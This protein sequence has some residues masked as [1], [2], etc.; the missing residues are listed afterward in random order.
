MKENVAD[1]G[2]FITTVYAKC[3]TSERR[4][5]W[6]NIHN[7]NNTIDG[8]WCIG[9]DFNIIMDTIEKLGGNP[10]RAYRS[11]V[12]I[13]TMESYGLMDIG[14]TGPRYTWCNNRRP[15]KRIWKRLDRIK[16]NDQWAQHF[17]NNTVKHFVRNGSDHRVILFKDDDCN[18]SYFHSILRDSRRRLQLHRMKNHRDRWIQGEDRIVKAAVKHFK[19][20]FNLNQQPSVSNDILNCIPNLITEQNNKR[21]IILPSEE[22]IKDTVFSMSIES[23]AGPDGFNEK[24]FQATWDIIKR[25][26]IEIVMDFFKGKNLTKFYSHTCIALIPKARL[27][28]LFS[29]TQAR[30]SF[31]PSLFILVAEV[32]TRSL[33]NLIHKENFTSFSMNK[34]GPQINYLAYADDIVIFCGGNSKTVKTVIK[35]IRKYEKASGQLVNK[36][37]SF[38]LTG[39]KTSAYR[40]NRLR[41]CTGFMD[42]SFPFTY[43]GCP[44]YVGRKKICFFDNMVTKIIKS[45]NGWQGKMLTYGRRVVLIKSVLQP[46]PTYTLTALNPPKG[47]LNLIEKH[48]DRFLWGTTGKKNNYHCSSWKILCFPKEEGDIEIKSLEDISATLTIKRWWRFRTIPLLWADFLRAKYCPRTHPVKK[49]WI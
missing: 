39:P 15:S 38:F 33:N 41:D 25:D 20:F 14:F 9:G 6:D 37:K 35:E 10:H 5:L 4:D 48:M 22:E 13:S 30:G 43:L 34:R 17:Q 27:L 26:I 19:S 31:I 18:T 12:F 24:K 23:S 42:K 3:T 46:L 7:M 40:I 29:W 47:T 16:I 32:L 1:S 8:P 45:L 36:D 28:Y 21:L 44:T 49:K 2:T 11:L